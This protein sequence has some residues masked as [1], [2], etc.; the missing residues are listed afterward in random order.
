MK[1]FDVNKAVEEFG[2]LD[3]YFELEDSDEEP[4]NGPEKE[5]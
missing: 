2:K 4:G 1:D 3:R 5:G